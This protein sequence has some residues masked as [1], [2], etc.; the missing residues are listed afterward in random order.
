MGKL[1][2]LITT[3][4]V[5]L[6]I[7]LLSYLFDIAIYLLMPFGII[8]GTFILYAFIRG[9]INVYKEYKRK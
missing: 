8:L 3:C 6:L 7:C 4:L 5:F 9:C 1:G 2:W